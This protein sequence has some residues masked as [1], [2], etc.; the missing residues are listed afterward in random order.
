MSIVLNASHMTINQL[1]AGI[2]G[3][4][5]VRAEKDE[6]GKFP[7]AQVLGVEKMNRTRRI[8]VEFLTG[9]DTGRQRLLQSNSIIR[10]AE[11]R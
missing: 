3:V 11:A 6:K 4:C 1:A 2:G 10:W 9:P 8:R 5:V 7:L